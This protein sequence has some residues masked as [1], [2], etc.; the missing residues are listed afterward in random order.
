MGQFQLLQESKDEIDAIGANAALTGK[1]DRSMSGRALLARSQSGTM[2]LGPVFDAHRAWK[3]RVYRQIWNRIRQYWTEERW[4]RV[5][6]DE[7]NL[8]YVGLNK[9]VT[10]AQA[11][12]EN[13]LPIPQGLENDPRL[14]ARVGTENLVAEMDVDIIIQESPDTVTI[15]G[16]Q[17]DLLVQMYQANPQG[18]PW[19]SVIEASSLRN[20]DQ[21]LGKKDLTPEQEQAQQQ[22]QQM[23]EAHMQLEMGEKQATIQEKEASSN[24][25]NAKAE[26][27]KAE[28]MKVLHEP[29]QVGQI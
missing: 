14:Q 26:K 17:F 10:A 28:A 5:T 25:K 9:P 24:E 4:V 27:N 23:A 19:E 12:E 11:F 18:I 6:D 21:I 16:E 8:K 15:Q 13:N 3:R 1:E 2:E 22:Q 7:N 20:K 29:I